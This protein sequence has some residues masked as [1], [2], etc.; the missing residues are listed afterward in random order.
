MIVCINGPGET[1]CFLTGMSHR[2]V[3]GVFRDGIEQNIDL[4]I[5]AG[6]NG[7]ADITVCQGFLRDGLIPRTE[8]FREANDSPE[9]QAMSFMDNWS[10]HLGSEVVD[11]FSAHN[12][13]II[14]FP[15]H[16]IG[17][18]QMGDLSFFGV[19]CRTM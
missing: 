9:S 14:A 5:H 3:L 10:S 1:L 16:S 19:L 11:L 4:K 18:F 12:V 15:P 7:Y 13:K 17:I 8:D 6:H 2:S